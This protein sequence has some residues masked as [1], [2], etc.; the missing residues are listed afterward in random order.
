MDMALVTAYKPINMSSLSV[1]FGTVDTA[2]ST[3]IIITDYL[4]KIGIYI[5]SGITYQNNAVTGGTLNAYGSYTY[6]YPDYLSDPVYTV[7]GLSLSAATVYSY[8]QSNRATQLSILALA[9]NDA[10]LG[11]TG[12]DYLIAYAGN[13]TLDG[14]SGNDTLVGGAG[15]DIYYVDSQSDV[16]V[17]LSK[18]NTSTQETFSIGNN[19]DAIVASVNYVLSEST[20]GIEDMLAAGLLT[21]STI[22]NAINLTGNSL[23]QGLIGNDANNTLNGK[24]GDDQL[25]GA[26]GN[27]TLIGEDGIDFFMSGAGD[28]S[29]SGGKGNDFF[30][31]NLGESEGTNLVGVRGVMALTGGKDTADGGEGTDTLFMRG[32][33]DN[34]II[35]RTSATEYKITVKSGITDV[36]S[37]EEI[38]FK[39]IERLA[40]GTLATLTSGQADTN[41]VLL[42][43]IS[44]PSALNDTLTAPNSSDW[45]INGL[46]GN[47][48]IT[49]GAGND[50]LDGGSGND[51]LFGG[52]GNDFFDFTTL[53]KASNNVDTIADFRSGDKI[54]LAKSVM[55]ELQNTSGNLAENAFYV[56]TSARDLDDR[57]IYDKKSGKLLYDADGNKAGG[58]AA[59]QIALIGSGSMKDLQNTDF[60]VI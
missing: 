58:V 48:S 21:G 30:S 16:V 13:D 18:D 54:R 34:Y 22:N 8:V 56:G 26:G 37:A 20:T 53:L 14:D 49:G 1:W 39:N 52:L 40:F 33:L 23:A 2:T 15:D 24:G 17:E 7:T 45:S 44:I 57:I 25:I 35:S 19:N 41:T 29:M 32:S 36:S 28:D 3:A 12:A 46:A 9:G 59:V 38:T 42:S 51:T 55:T 5:G 10:F 50:T 47:D 4:T 43:S 31:F 11:S 6:R 60:I 27:D